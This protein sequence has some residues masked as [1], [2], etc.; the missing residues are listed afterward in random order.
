M[1]VLIIAV[2]G[3]ANANSYTEVAV[4]D[5]YCNDRLHAEAATEASEDNKA[6]ALIEATREL[7]V[8]NWLGNRSTDTQALAWPRKNVLNPDSSGLSTYPISVI[9]QRIIDATCELALQFLKAGSSDLASLDANDGVIRKKVDVLETEWAA[10]QYRKQGLALFPRVLKL[11]APLIE[12]NSD[13][14]RLVRG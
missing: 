9:P 11:V 12:S 13:Q 2:P 1:A 10:P 4:F 6:R 5:A 8:L 14:V 3:A 7:T